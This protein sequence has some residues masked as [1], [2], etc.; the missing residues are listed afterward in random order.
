MVMLAGATITTTIKRTEAAPTVRTAGQTDDGRPPMADMVLSA[1]ELASDIEKGATIIGEQLAPD[2]VSS[3][4]FTSRPIEAPIPFNAVVPQWTGDNAEPIVLQVRTSPDGENWDD[5]VEVR[6][7]HDW[8]EPGEPEIIG[9]MVFVSAARTTHRFIQI[10]IIFE[11]TSDPVERSTLDSLRL[12]FIDTADGPTV[13]ELLDLQTDIEKGETLLPDSAEG[14]PRPFVVS[15]EAWCTHPSCNYTAGIR[16]RTV[17]HLIIHHTVSNNNLTDWPAAVRAV[18]SYH[19]FGREWGDIGY[20]YLIDPNG[21]IYEGHKGGDDVVGIHA[22]G[23]NDGS[24]GVVLLGTFSTVSPPQAMLNA[25]VDLLSWKADQRDINVFDAGRMPYLSWGLPFLSGHRDVY[26]TTECPGDRAHLLIPWLREQIAARIGLVDPFLY[27][28]ERTT[29]FTRSSTGSWLVPRYLCGFNNHSWY[30]WSTSNPNATV[31]WGEWRPRVPATGRY[32]IDVFVPRCYTNRAETKSATY[33]IRHAG[34]TDTRTVSQEANV[35]LWITLGEY[36]L[37]AGNGNVVRLTN[38][39]GDD[40]L[41][42]W[43]DAIRLLPKDS[44]PPPSLPTNTDP[45]A[46]A[47]RNT[48]TINFKWQITNPTLVE[49]TTLQVATDPGFSKVLVNQSWHGAPTSH[50][51]TFD[52]DYGNLYW[53]VLLARPNTALV[54]SAPTRFGLDATPPRSAV[55]SPLIALPRSGNYAVQWSGSD[56]TSGIVRYNIDIRPKGGAWTRWLTNVTYRATYF[57]PPIAGQVYE[58]RSQA[59]DLAGNTEVVGNNAQASTAV[60][61]ILNKFT[62][63]PSIAR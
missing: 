15:R 33:T 46:N 11:E 34:G 62:H 19:T 7:N 35:G 2:S 59:I 3:A 39:T 10:Q 44:P 21:V 22:S 42:V 27:A 8:M 43:F 31:A 53:R 9:E 5:W 30:V 32:R 52:R 29:A 45:P 23:A 4:S 63:L 58:F 54:S 61:I 13:D 57:T 37:N 26:G 18:W 49:V 17:T 55:E 40:G 51:H 28:D 56:E 16:Y 50:T 41:G 14:Y 60:A 24:M 12:T 1:G 47:W 6:A 48:R 20:N 38:L 25:T 36:T